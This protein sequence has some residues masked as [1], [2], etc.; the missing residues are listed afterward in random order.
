MQFSFCVTA[1]FKTNR[2][3]DSFSKL[4]PGRAP[5]RVRLGEVGHISWLHYATL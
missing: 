4:D 2:S 3:Q 1:V 5:R